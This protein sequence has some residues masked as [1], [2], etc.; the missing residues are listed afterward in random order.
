MAAKPCAKNAERRG[1]VGG[2][3]APA[4]LLRTMSLL[5]LALTIALCLL[6]SCLVFFLR[7]QTRRPCR[8]AVRVP[9]GRPGPAAGGPA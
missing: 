8:D 1:R 3:V 9:A 5:P 4:T 7:D 6:F 2:T